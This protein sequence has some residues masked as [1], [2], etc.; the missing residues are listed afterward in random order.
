MSD[1]KF[2]M[3]KPTRS[4][5]LNEQAIGR[6]LRPETSPEFRVIYEEEII[7]YSKRSER[8]IAQ[9]DSKSTTLSYKCSG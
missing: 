1:E 5:A 9:V 8:T 4:P 6:C 3:L 2:V 7:R